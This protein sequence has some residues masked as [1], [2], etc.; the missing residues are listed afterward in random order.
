MSP[1]S[2][3][4]TAYPSST[5]EHASA[6]APSAAR[7]VPF[8]IVP[9]DTTAFSPNRVAT[10]RHNFHEHPMLQLPQL[11]LLA[12]ELMLDS[13][14][15]FLAPGTTVAS[16]FTHSPRSPLKRDLDEVFRRIEEPGTWIALYNIETI[17]RYLALLEEIIA[18]VRPH[19][20]R[21]QRDIIKMTGFIFIS[22]PPSVTPFHIDR[23]NNFWLQLRGHKTITTWDREDRHTVAAADVDDFIVWRSLDK[24]RLKDDARARGREL[25]RG[26]GEGLYFP[27]TT[28]HMT[29]SDTDWVRPGDGVAISIGVNFYTN[30]TRRH[31]LVH[32]AN[33]MLRRL[34]LEP[35]P[36]RRH[37]WL[38]L[39]KVPIGKL[40]IAAHRRRKGGYVLPPGLD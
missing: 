23:E 28:P 11:E 17:P 34:G 16:E 4:T 27:S 35:T 18:T 14:C 32:Q 9:D 22:A 40:A 2:A 31:A 38:D 26:P 24:V 25:D 30:V 8:A 20:E 36:P 13:K 19:I 39:L 10:L 12:K 21:E 29:V 6:A 5:P 15:R 1:V 3:S 37:A 33:W 7:P